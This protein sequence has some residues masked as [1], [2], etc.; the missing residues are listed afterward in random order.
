MLPNGN[1][2][3]NKES[4]RNEHLLKREVFVELFAEEITVFAVLENRDLP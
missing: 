1:L 2:Q 3:L 4:T